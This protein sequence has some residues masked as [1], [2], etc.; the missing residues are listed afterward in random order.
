MLEARLNTIATRK[1]DLNERDWAAMLRTS[2]PLDE[3]G[4]GNQAQDLLEELIDAYAAP[5]DERRY[6]GA[7]VTATRGRSDFWRN[8]WTSLASSWARR[9]GRRSC[10]RR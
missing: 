9:E 10:S 6:W 5:D 2:D 4:I 1:V 3:A 7:A 8:G